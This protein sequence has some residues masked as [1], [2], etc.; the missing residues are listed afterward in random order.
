[1]EFIDIEDRCAVV[2]YVLDSIIIP[3]NSQVCGERGSNLPLVLKIGHVKRAAVFVAAPG[4][5]ELNFI[6]RGGEHARITEG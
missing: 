4:S 5:I 1:V 3:A 2:R 6:K